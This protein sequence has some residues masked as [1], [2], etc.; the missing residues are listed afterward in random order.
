MKYYQFNIG[1]YRAHTSHLEPMEDLAYRRLLDWYYTNEK[2]VPEDINE[3]ARLI[4]MRSHCDCIAMVLREFFVL[5][6]DVGW[7][8]ARADFEIAEFNEKSDKAR[9]SANARWSKH[10]KKQDIKKRNTTAMR[11]HTEGNANKEPRTK[12]QEPIIKNQEHPPSAAPDLA[13]LIFAQGKNI[14]GE[15][16]GSIIGQARKRV[17]DSKV[18]EVLA[19]LSVARPPISDPVPYFIRATTPKVRGVVV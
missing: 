12:N 15:K 3:V 9:V 7:R 11:S 10:H 6:K 5:T 2:P 19:A 4:G 17:G 13:S 8:N 18:A 16:A 1:D 14:L